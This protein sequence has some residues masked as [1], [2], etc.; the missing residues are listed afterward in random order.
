MA[1]ANVKPI[2]FTTLT[3]LSEKLISEHHDVLY[4]GY[5]K[6]LNEIRVKLADADLSEA[7]ASYSLFGELK[8]E[9]TFTA[10]GVR[11]HEAYFDGLG[12][13]GV[14]SG[15]ILKL[16]ERD[17]GSFE[18]WKDYM[19]AAGIASRGWV[20]AAYDW[21]SMELVCYTCDTHNLGCVWSASPLVVLD[22]YEH[23]YY[24]DYAT[25][26]K[27]YIG[28]WFDNLDFNHANSIIESLRISV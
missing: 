17:C 13:N 10:N 22:V 14:P 11:L 23:A 27:A 24:L 12:G 9:E 1:E 20:V 16:I 25:A 3:G 7:N 19:T 28:A 2:A 15:S 4:A 26:R 6:K 8:R 21:A 18:N 5:V